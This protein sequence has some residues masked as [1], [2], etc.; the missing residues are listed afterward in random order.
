MHRKWVA[1]L[2]SAAAA[3]GIVIGS[4]WGLSPG[5]AAAGVG[6]AS[7]ST[8]SAGHAALRSTLDRGPVDRQ[9]PS[10]ADD[11]ASAVVGIGAIG[12]GAGGIALLRRRR[13]T[14]RTL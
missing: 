1:R 6:G 5:A 8:S 2:G 12:F 9:V 10:G 14:M 13:R 11:A 7:S 3:V 4:A